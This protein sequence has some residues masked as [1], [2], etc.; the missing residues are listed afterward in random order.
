MICFVTVAKA[1]LDLDSLVSGWELQ[2]D[3]DAAVLAAIGDAA[4]RAGAHDVLVKGDVKDG[5]SSI[6]VD[7]GM[8]G[9]A[10]GSDGGDVDD[11]DLARGRRPNSEA[12][13]RSD[14][15]DGSASE[16]KTSEETH[17]E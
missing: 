14:S 7:I 6:D 3:A 9:R 2:V 5:A 15:S 17:L 4:A 11:L 13:A 16:E 8:A 10:A 12:S 1:S